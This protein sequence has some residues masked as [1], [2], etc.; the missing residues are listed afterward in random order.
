MLHDELEILPVDRLARKVGGRFRLVTLVSK[1]LRAVNNGDPYLVE[2]HPGERPIE[3]VCRE[4]EEGKIWLETPEDAYAT[5]REA[6][7][8]EDLLDTSEFPPSS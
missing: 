2:A 6:E 8:M 4:I 7:D 3:T 1:R 5:M